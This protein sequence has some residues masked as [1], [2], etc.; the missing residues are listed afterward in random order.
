MKKVRWLTNA[1]SC[2]LGFLLWANILPLN[3]EAAI[4]LGLIW[5]L[6]YIGYNVFA[7]EEDGVWDLLV[8]SVLIGLASPVFGLG[9]LLTGLNEK[10]LIKK[11]S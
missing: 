9:V 4:F 10:H 11:S 8:H 3:S 7:D 6:G 5:I 2:V 1:A